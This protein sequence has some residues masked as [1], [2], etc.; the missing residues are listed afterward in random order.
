MVQLIEDQYPRA[1]FPEVY[2]SLLAIHRGQEQS[3]AQLKTSARSGHTLEVA[4]ILRISCAKGG[5]SVLADA[6][7]AQPWLTEQEIRFSFE[8]GVLLQ[9]GDDLQ[10]VRDDLGR[11]SIT[12]FTRAAAQG[13][14]LDDFVLQLLHFSQQ[15]ADQMDRLPNGSPSLKHLLR[16]SWRSLILMAVANAPSF[17]SSAFLDDLETFSAFR[18]DFLRARNQKL[19]GRQSLYSCVFDAFVQSD[20]VDCAVPVPSKS[21]YAPD[22]KLSAQIGI[23]AATFV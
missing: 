8:W 14:P 12:L 23:S 15:I 11:G 16:M 22:P 17:F 10:D 5:T 2:A 18:F 13:R 21:F 9:L 19:T 3:I 4:D 6:C 1:R 20:T 7:L